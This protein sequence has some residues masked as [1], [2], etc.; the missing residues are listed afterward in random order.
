MTVFVTESLKFKIKFY[1]IYSNFI[2]IFNFNQKRF[3][4][5][6]FGREDLWVEIEMIHKSKRIIKIV[7]SEEKLLAAHSNQFASTQN[8]FIVTFLH[9]PSK[10]NETIKMSN[11]LNHFLTKNLPLKAISFASFPFDPQFSFPLSTKSNQ[12]RNNFLSLF[13]SSILITNFY[14]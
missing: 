4:E 1:Q 2:Q 6:I 5:W 10:D 9:K 13:A 3:T 8:I 7:D 14:D 12:K 11:N